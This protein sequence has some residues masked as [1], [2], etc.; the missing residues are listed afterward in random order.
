MFLFAALFVVTQSCDVSKNDDVLNPDCNYAGTCVYKDLF[1]GF[2]IP[3]C[4]CCAPSTLESDNDCGDSWVCD[5]L[6]PTL[7]CLKFQGGDCSMVLSYYFVKLGFRAREI[8][9]SQPMDLSCSTDPQTRFQSGVYGY[10]NVYYHKQVEY[11]VNNRGW[12]GSIKTYYFCDTCSPAFPCQMASE[13]V[14]ATVGIGSAFQVDLHEY[15]GCSNGL[16]QEVGDM[17]ECPENYDMGQMAF[18]T[19]SDAVRDQDALLDELNQLLQEES[20]ASNNNLGKGW[21]NTL[22]YAV[23]IASVSEEITIVIKS[24]T[25]MPTFKPTVTPTTLAPTFTPTAS[26]TSVPTPNPTYMPTPNPTEMPTPNPTEMPTPNPTDMPTTAPTKMPTQAPTKMPTQA[27]TKMPTQAPTKMP[28]QAPSKQP[29][30]NSCAAYTNNLE[31]LEFRGIGS[32]CRAG[33]D[34]SGR[35]E[36]FCNSPYI[37]C[38][39]QENTP[40]LFGGELYHT[41][42]HRYSVSECL[43]ECANDQRCLGVEFIPDS[44]SALGDC[45]LIDDIP[46]EITPVVSSFIYDRT[47][48]YSNLDSSVTNGTALCFEKVDFCYPYFEAEDLNEDMLNC[49]CPN[50]RKG[51]YTKRVKR[52]VSNTRFCGD[53]TEVNHRIQKAQANRMFHLCE[54][55]CLFQTENPEAES[56]YWDPWKTCWREQYAGVVGMH[57]SYCS[58]VIRNPNTI[59]MQFVNY[60]KNHFCL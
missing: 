15:Y 35:G 23:N 21:T 27:P 57:M 30:G 45:N 10:Q 37:V 54:N 46:L 26:P 33:L 5:P 7:K 6:N 9:G 34:D 60:R 4:S 22:V 19:W 48:T 58:R 28:T 31:S 17:G 39:P 53:D 20:S 38:L 55:W 49:Y 41:S 51:F 32:D 47:M 18:K 14:N 12:N 42:T 52:T 36:L 59:E 11:V 8:D 3:Q 1:P 2:A 29:T 43:R 13:G 40:A 25:L 44:T 56:W 16:L 50:N 24:P